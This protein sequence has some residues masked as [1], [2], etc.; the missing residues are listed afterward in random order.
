MPMIK[1]EDQ[2]GQRYEPGWDVIR[3]ILAHRV[4]LDACIDD[5]AIELAV[6]KTAGVLRH[7]FQTLRTA[8][9]AAGQDFKRGHRD[10]ERI[11]LSD[12]RYGLDRMKN[13]I[14]SRIGVMGLPEEFK[15]IDTSHLYE[16]LEEFESP[17]RVKADRIN[18]LLMQAHALLEYNG[19]QWHRVHPLVLEYLEELRQP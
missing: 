8:A 19:K 7:L 16:R 13:D 14:I 15:G 2:G 12:V 5:D 4:N 10:Q 3:D 17:R 11:T 18:L 6:A 9:R 1:V